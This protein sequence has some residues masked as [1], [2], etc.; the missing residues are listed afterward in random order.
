MAAPPSGAPSFFR[1]CRRKRPVRLGW[2]M[3]ETDIGVKSRW[4]YLYRAMDKSSPRLIGQRP[5]KVLFVCTQN[6]ARSP[7]AEAIFRELV[8]GRSQHLVRSVGIA[9][10]AL[11]RL[12]TR[13]LAWADVIVVM[14]PAHL[15]LIKRRWPKQA[16]KVWVLD[17]P[18]DYDPGEPE[19]RA[20]LTPKIRTLLEGLDVVEPPR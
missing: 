5:M 9:S 20:V 11:Q 12:T 19:L 2:R 14:E 3:D 8:G 13:D 18:D 16:A 4:E 6:V 7:L 15:A 17:V 1:I 10:S